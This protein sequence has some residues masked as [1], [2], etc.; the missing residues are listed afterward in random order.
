MV[1]AARDTGSVSLEQVYAEACERHPG[2]VFSFDAFTARAPDPMP[3]TFHGADFFLACAAAS[4]L[5]RAV[6]LIDENLITPL[7]D[8]LARRRFSATVADEALQRVRIKLFTGP[9][10]AIAGYR[11]RGSLAA[12]LKV[13]AVRTALNLVRES[14][15]E[16]ELGDD[17]L[18][19]ASA[20]RG[21]PHVEG[22]RVW[23]RT[24][25]DGVLA[26]AFRAL[27]LR[28]RNLLR[29][30]HLDRARIA[31][32]AALHGVHRV[33]LSI[34]LRAAEEALATEVRRLL[35]ARVDLPSE[36]I[37]TLV[38]LVRS[39]IDLSLRTMMD[40]RSH[41]EAS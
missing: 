2:V 12:W 35:G 29:Q 40:T 28:Q 31:D 41:A 16:V 5:A 6:A 11:G 15:R 10:P 25:L 39:K 27:D 7:A 30:Y 8:E 37:D 38:G 19:S 22:L 18:G 20:G 34:W 1:R 36:E 23:S 21:D 9:T 14:A 26:E 24:D 17:V 32:L 13:C 33:T 4:G 3:A